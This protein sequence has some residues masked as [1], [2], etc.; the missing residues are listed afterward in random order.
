MP[1]YRRRGNAKR[2]KR[3]RNSMRGERAWKGRGHK[4]FVRLISALLLSGAGED[5]S[6]TSCDRGRGESSSGQS[7]V[8]RGAVGQDAPLRV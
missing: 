1:P 4:E 6:A 7:V 8:G 2:R 5:A 3:S